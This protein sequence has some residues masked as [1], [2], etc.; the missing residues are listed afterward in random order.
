MNIL[1]AYSG[2]SAHLL[3]A[4]HSVGE[5]EFSPA[6]FQN[7]RFCDSLL[8]RMSQDLA[9]PS[10][11]RVE[12]YTTLLSAGPGGLLAF[13]WLLK[14]GHISARFLDNYV[15]CLQVGAPAPEALDEK[16]A[17]EAAD[18]LLGYKELDESQQLSFATRLLCC[19][20]FHRASRLALLKKFLTGNLISSG[21]RLSLAL[22]STH[23]ALPGDETGLQ[24]GD[25]LFRHG[26]VARAQMGEDVAHLLQYYSGAEPDELSP[27]RAEGLLDLL[28]AFPQ[29][30]PAGQR[31]R[32]LLELREHV[33]PRVRRRAYQLG[34]SSEGESFLRVGLRD[35]D[36]GVRSWVLARVSQRGQD[37]KTA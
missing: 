5:S 12:V 13:M 28:E 34:E 17:I 3:H 11:V 20:A 32:L 8:Q 31:Q 16:S 35:L 27:T 7:L 9:I 36:A 24:A 6:L 25:E 4:A 33:D 15:G 18:V 26:L 10:A 19:T 30:S 14:E 1:K 23:T 2:M 29:G 21:C 22:W 37:S